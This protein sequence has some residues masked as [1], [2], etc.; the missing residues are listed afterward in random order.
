MSQPRFSEQEVRLAEKAARTQ[1][2][3]YLCSHPDPAQY[4]RALGVADQRQTVMVRDASVRSL[5]LLAIAQDSLF[6][7]DIAETDYHAGIALLEQA[8][9]VTSRLRRE[10]RGLESPA[11][12]IGSD[13]YGLRPRAREVAPRKRRAR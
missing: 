3:A 2:E 11:V 12:K 4:A 6:A 5:T 1:Q 8:E 7:E 10:L 13:W 9:L